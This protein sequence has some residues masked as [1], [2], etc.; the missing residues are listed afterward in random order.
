MNTYIYIYVY[1]YIRIYK[2]IYIGM[3]GITQPRRVA[4][5][6]TAERCFYVYA[7]KMC[8]CKYLCIYMYKIIR[9]CVS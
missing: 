7:I 1:K 6:S 9:I 3:I 8:V 4:A 2:Y 5:T